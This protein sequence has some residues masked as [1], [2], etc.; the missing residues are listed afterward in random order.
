MW[1]AFKV[2]LKK[3][4]AWCKKNW[5]LFIGAAVPLILMLVFRK[6]DDL[7]KV[8]ERVNEDYQKEIESIEAAHEKEIATRDEAITIFFETME[9]VEAEYVRRNKELDGAEREKI[10]E[11]LDNN[12]EDP[13]EITRKIALIT[14][15]EIYTD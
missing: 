12:V 2:W 3:T 15:F 8:L 1:L 10:Q 9:D 11:L 14:G 4:W 13:E 6:G 5:Q 7:K